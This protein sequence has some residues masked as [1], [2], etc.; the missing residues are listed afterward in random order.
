[1]ND[2]FRA[3][4]YHSPMGRLLLILLVMLLPLRGWSAERMVLQMILSQAALQVAD[5]Q[6]AMSGMPA[7]CPMMARPASEAEKSPTPSKSHI[8][9]QTCQLCMTLA[10]PS[11]PSTDLLTYARQTHPASTSA[12]FISADLARQVKP[13]IL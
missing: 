13:P 12:S 10:T 2:C 8:G 6:M 1:M 4:G 11:F 3:M 5:E 7:D 9:C